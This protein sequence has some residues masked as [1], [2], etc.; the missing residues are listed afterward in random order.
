[1]KADKTNNFYK[2][3]PE[4]YKEKLDVNI[5]KMYKKANEYHVTEINTEAK[6]ITE[7]LEISDRVDT[8]ARRD[9][10]ITLKDHKPNFDNA[11][12]CRLISPTKSEIGRISKQILQRIVKETSTAAKINLWRNTRAVLDWFNSIENKQ[13]AYFVCFDIVDFYPSITEKLLINAVEFAAKYTEISDLDSQIIMHAKKTLLFSNDVP[14]SKK[15]G[16]ANLFDVTMGSY[17]GAETCE[18][19]AVY[20][21]DQ[22]ATICKDKAGLYRDDGL[23]L[24]HE[25]PRKIEKIKKKICKLF[26]SNGLRITIEANKKVINYLDVTLDLNTEKHQPFMKANNNPQYVHASSNHPPSILR[27]IPSN[28]NRRLSNIS[29][30][31]TVFNNTTQPYQTALNNSGY[32]HQLSYNHGRQQNGPPNRKR[33]RKRKITWYN[34][35]FDMRVKTNVGKQFLRT[36]DECFPRGHVLRPIFNRNTVKISYSCMPNI[37]NIVDA[38][39]K[40]LLKRPNEAMQQEKTCN[41]R[42]KEECPLGNKCLTR[43]VIYQATVETDEERQTYIGMTDTEFK[44]RYRNHKQSFERDRYEGQTELS[45]FIWS[46][47]RSSIPFHISWEIVDRATSYSP[48]TKRCNL[49]ILEKYYILRHKERA[50]LNKRSELASNCR[51][52]LKFTLQKLN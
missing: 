2:M 26:A 52:A 21:L 24:L 18:L 17:D 1:M 27:S 9:C 51:H 45:K 5:Q 41:C 39:N 28:I 35:P 16:P 46:L 12:T 47:K 25:N 34:P 37:K 49:C 3:R 15:D 4:Q 23:V 14:W 43:S 48:I 29:S 13:D 42:K 7:E 44:T 50:S 10:F 30:D 11:P 8:M 22:L 6:K 20:M 33:S 19:I 32:T 40:K 36:V 38:H 31:E